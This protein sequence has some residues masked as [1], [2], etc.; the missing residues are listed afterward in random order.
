[1]ATKEVPA[2]SSHEAL[3]PAPSWSPSSRSIP[4]RTPHACAPSPGAG[5]L[6]DVDWA[7]EELRWERQDLSEVV[8][9]AHA[10]PRRVEP[11]KSRRAALLTWQAR[12]A[13]PESAGARARW[14]CLRPRPIEEVPGAP[15]VRQPPWPED[16]G[17]PRTRRSHATGTRDRQ[18]QVPVRQAVLG[19]ECW[20]AVG[21]MMQQP[22]RFPSANIVAARAADEL[23]Y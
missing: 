6:G 20:R 14:R 11:T 2:A 7:P 13:A 21:S 17:R 18:P 10:L 19:V 22:W 3:M 23:G 5:G 12:V 8:A 4:R 16:G 9:H 15:S 1:M